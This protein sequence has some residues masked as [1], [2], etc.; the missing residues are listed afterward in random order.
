MAC[1]SLPIYF[2]SL[3]E[4]SLLLIGGKQLKIPFLSVQAFEIFKEYKPEIFYCGI[5]S[6]LSNN[7]NK[8]QWGLAAR[9]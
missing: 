8:N 5:T 7:E 4:Y 2:N 1:I 9:D 6:V 3:G